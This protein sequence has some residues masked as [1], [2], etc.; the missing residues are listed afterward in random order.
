MSPR[1][2][3]RARHGGGAG[4]R[5]AAPRPAVSRHLRRHAIDGD[6]RARIRGRRRPRLD[7]RRRRA[8]SGSARTQDSPH[9]LE[10]AAS[11][12]RAPVA[13]RNRHRRR[14]PARLFR[15]LVPALPGRSRR[16]RRRRRL[17]RPGDCDGRS[18]KRRRDAVPSREEPEARPRVDRQFPEVASL[19]L[20]P[21]IDLKSGECVRLVRG[22]MTQATVFNADPAGAGAHLPGARLRVAAPRRPRRRL[23]RPADER[24]RGRSHPRQRVDEGSARRRR[25]RH[26][27]GRRLAGEGRRARHHRHR[28]GRGPRLSCARLRGCFP[29]ASPSASTRATAASPSTAGRAPPTSRRSTSAAVSRTPASRR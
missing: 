9:G 2:R 18:R 13:G 20:F 10:H 17:R 15:P 22:D 5:G 21:A 6:A 7:R 28:R 8:D 19:I 27:D 1:P 11:S 26:E 25:A 23:R 4:G 24:R 14:R 16:R 3:R 29:A 12:S